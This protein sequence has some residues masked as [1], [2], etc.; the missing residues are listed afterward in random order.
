MYSYQDGREGPSGHWL[1]VDAIVACSVGYSGGAGHYFLI[2]KSFG[3]KR[4]F[5]L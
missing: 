2:K 1:I 4:V 3:E 5:D